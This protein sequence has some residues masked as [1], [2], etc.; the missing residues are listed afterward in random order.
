MCVPDQ[1]P[2]S[3]DRHVAGSTGCEIEIELRC[4][5]CAEGYSGESVGHRAT[6][7]CGTLTVCV[8]VGRVTCERD[9]VM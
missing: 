3:L 9:E 4:C 8:L 7:T 2:G 5:E 1:R 6:T